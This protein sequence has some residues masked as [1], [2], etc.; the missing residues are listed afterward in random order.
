MDNDRQ[1]ISLRLESEIQEQIKKR[2]SPITEAEV[3]NVEAKW[4]QLY[5]EWEPPNF[6]KTLANNTLEDRLDTEVIVD[7][8][9]KLDRG[10]PLG[11]GYT[12]IKDPTKYAKWQ[13]ISQSEAGQG[14]GPTRDQDHQYIDSLVRE[15]LQMTEGVMNTKDTVYRTMIDNAKARYAY[16]YRLA[17]QQIGEKGM[18]LPQTKG[19]WALQQ[20]KAE[21]KSNPA[22]FKIRT[23]VDPKA[24]LTAD[25]GVAQNA[26]SEGDF[27]VVTSGIIPGTESSYKILETQWVKNPNSVD[28]LPPIYRILANTIAKTQTGYT[29]WRLARDQYKAVTGKELPEPKQISALNRKPTLTQHLMTFNASPRTVRQAAIE[30]KNG[31]NY[32][33][34]GMLTNGVTV[35]NKDSTPITEEVP[36]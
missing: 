29:A 10:L 30:D 26:L 17:P 22:L 23:T 27:T 3:K 28:S 31:G 36:Q 34:E 32:N 1:L 11:N 18:S 21:M 14:L 15:E 12:K 5:P 6:L 9:Y 33:G 8:Q 25:L 19:T 35:P 13:K 7:L 20:V 4:R 16:W 24:Q 2:N